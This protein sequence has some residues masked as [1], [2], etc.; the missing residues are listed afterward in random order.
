M[1][2]YERDYFETSIWSYDS[3]YCKHIPKHLL[4][5]FRYIYTATFPTE[6][7]VSKRCHFI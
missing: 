3:N 6:A 2:P 4:A 1:S 7:E 5:Q